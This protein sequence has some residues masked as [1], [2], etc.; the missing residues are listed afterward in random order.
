MIEKLLNQMRVQARMA[1][2]NL[3]FTRMGKIT[4]FDPNNYTVKVIIEPSDPEDP[5]ASLTGWIPLASQWVGN[6]WGMFAPPA[7]GAACL[8]HFS[9]ASFQGAIVSLLNFN[10][11]Y[12]PVSVDAG[13]FWLLH[14]TGSFIKLQNNGNIEVFGNSTVNINAENVHVGNISAGNLKK[15]LTEAAADIYNM[16][17]H[18]TPS[19]T[20]DAPTQQMT[21]SEMTQ[22]TEAN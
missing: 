21:S 19:G 5:N 3:A 4:N 22:H 13:E 2:S 15:L 20:S 14:E 12:R 7:I 6:G 1:L 9:E 18:V 17:T 8:V 16:H 11:S 10:N